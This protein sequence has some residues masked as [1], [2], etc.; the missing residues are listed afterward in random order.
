MLYSI[1]YQHIKGVDDLVK[2]LH[3]NK[4]QDLVDIRSKPYSRKAAF[5]KNNLNK[6]LSKAGIRFWW[7]GDTLGGFSEIDEADIKKLAFWQQDKVACLMCMEADPDRCHRKIEIA[8][9]LKKYGVSVDHI[10]T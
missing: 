9:R 6:N 2:I 7:F 3:K 10:I 4:I 8:K 5:N 1:G